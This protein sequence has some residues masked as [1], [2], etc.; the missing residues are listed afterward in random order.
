MS[1]APGAS[2]PRRWR[3]SRPL[4][5][6]ALAGLAALLLV[7][8][9]TSIA[10]RRV[11][12]REAIVTARTNTVVLVE[13]VV[14]PYVTP[15][16]LAGDPTAVTAL[17]AAVRRNV[18]TDDLVRVKIWQP[19]GTIL[20]SDRPELVGARYALGAD[21]V[22]SLRTGAIEAEVS[23][24][25]APENR[26]EATFDKLLE[27]YLPIQLAG[28]DEPVL[29]EAYYRYSIVSDNGSRLWHSF[30]P[31]A[32]AALVLLELIQIP[33]AWS[34]A[35]RLR[36]R[37]AE[38][39]LLLQRAVD[40]SEIERR[41]IASD[42][43]D[44]T[45]QDLAGVAYALAAAVRRSDAP[46]PAIEEAAEGVRRSIRE[47][48]SLIVDIYP[49]DL[50][51]VGLASALGDLLARASDRGLQVEL[52]TDELGADPVPDAVA[53]L[54]FRSAQEGLRNTLSHAGASTVSLVVAR[55]N[56]TAVLDLTDD[57]VGYDPA[58]TPTESGHVGLPALRGLVEGSGGTVTVSGAGASGT[59][60]HVEVP[61]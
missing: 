38:R 45:V 57:G 56:G 46:D 58:A 39:E 7:G 59:V 13:S 61:W 2:P 42:L 15:Q 17:D 48:R 5:Q 30:A 3:V 50:A 28:R 22:A 20:Y 9:A 37:L 32:L 23:D 16:L 54:L 60:L 47:L 21:E 27:V 35:R 24:L 49:P 51:E 10:S 6:F 8:V 41:Q 33:I 40:A 4:A 26:Y 12:T 25:S 52:D 34:L 29:F 36:D 14:R 18:L 43:H 1:S 53:R 31:I 55:R 19:D 44:G 11:G